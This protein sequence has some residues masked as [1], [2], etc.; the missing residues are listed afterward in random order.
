MS[1][2]LV[3]G[4]CVPEASVFLAQVGFTVLR[5]GVALPAP[6]GDEPVRMATSGDQCWLYRQGPV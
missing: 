4:H 1:P 3:A 6:L 2:T 5:P